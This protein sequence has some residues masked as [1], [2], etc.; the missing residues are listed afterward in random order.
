MEWGGG[1]PALRLAAALHA[2]HGPARSPLLPPALRHAARPSRALLHAA[3]SAAASAPPRCCGAIRSRG[4]GARPAARLA[5]AASSAAWPATSSAA[6][7]AVQAA[8]RSAHGRSRGGLR[9]LGLLASPR[10]SPVRCGMRGSEAAGDAG[11]WAAGD[12]REEAGRR[13]GARGGEPAQLASSRGVGKPARGRGGGLPARSQAG[14]ELALGGAGR[15][16]A[17]GARWGGG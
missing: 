15:Q 14:E 7:S 13:R 16:R 8:T 12:A 10:S 2:S 1:S 9:P 11:V 6:R 4:G 3:Q 5:A 17:G